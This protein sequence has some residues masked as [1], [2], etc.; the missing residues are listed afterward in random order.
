MDAAPDPEPRRHDEDIP[1]ADTQ[2]PVTAA[3]E[4]TTPGA[5]TAASSPPA[6]ES[7]DGATAKGPRVSRARAR[8]VPAKPEPEA[9][10]SAASAFT[11]AVGPGT[12]DDGGTSAPGPVDGSTVAPDAEVVRG[13]IGRLDARSVAVTQ[14]AIGAGRAESLSLEMSAIGL[15]GAGDATLSRS[16]ARAVLAGEVNLEQSA[17]Q[18]ILAERVTMTSGSMALVVIARRVEGEVR[19]LLDWRGGL[20][21]GAA[22]GL[23]MAILRPG[24]RRR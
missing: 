23:V 8:T 10:P 20:A 18:T 17:A 6:A 22:I 16:I 7:G 15:A 12:A 14:G 3:D 2:T 9:L 21:L 11:S 4:P 19:P 1:M 24:R 5:T 13:A